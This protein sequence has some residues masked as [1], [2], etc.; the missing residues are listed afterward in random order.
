[1]NILLVTQWFDPE[2]AFKGLVFAKA[3][4]AQGNDVEVITGFPNYPGGKLY[5]NYRI[6]WLTREVMDGIRVNRVPLYPSH[7][8]SALGR[9][10]N[11]LSFAISSCI[12]G[13]LGVRRPDV[14]YAYHPPLTTAVSAAVIS[15][16][17]RAP[18]VVDVN[19]LWPDSLAAT[20]M[21]S[22]RFA[23]T[24]VDRVC[25]W[26]YKRA[27]RV[28][29]GA[30]GT[31][32]RL[33]ERGVPPEKIEV[34]YNW[35]DE[36]ALRLPETSDASDF[37]MAGRF[38][39]VFAGNMGKAQ[40]LD[41]VIRAAGRVA[42]SAPRVQFVFVGGGV[43]VENLRVLAGTQRATNVRFLPRMPM[44]EVGKVLAAADVLLVHL[45]DDALF[46]I[47]IP[48]K[49]QA[50]MCVGKPVLMGVRGD[51][52]RLVLAAGA[53]R[54]AVP[55]DEESIAEAVTTMA[56]EPPGVLADMGSRG[57]AFY[58]RELS[59]ASGT[60]KFLKLFRGILQ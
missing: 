59:L 13:L 25:Q 54:L 28:V 44:N 1:M 2:P 36:Q 31:G 60:D 29:V 3:L 55:E 26:V 42:S 37:G 38:N 19:D 56:Q 35:S 27:A 8:G 24:V 43:E 11:Y 32:A 49:T 41:A 5:P 39:V 4:Q 22:N 34:I 46:E 40:A 15:A 50:Y 30:P 53:G 21:V 7:S 51:A 23:L 14:I 18:F 48:S 17:R 12:F 9:V 52:A 58:T 6:R 10:F 47:T 33:I 16:F 57:A 45:K 20:G